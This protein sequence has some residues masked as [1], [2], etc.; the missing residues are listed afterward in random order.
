[1][2]P[3]RRLVLAVVLVLGATPPALAQG[4]AWAE[5]GRL[6]AFAA[7][8]R[9]GGAGWSGGAASSSFLPLGSFGGF[10][11][12]AP[13]PGQGLGVMSR[14]M[15]SES[16]GLSPEMAMPGAVSGLGPIR[17]SLSP[18]APITAGGAGPMGQG[19]PMGGAM[20]PA[21]RGPRPMGRPPVGAYPFRI[22]PSLIG[23][24][25]SGP[26]MAM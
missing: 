24:A 20:R 10:V 14:G 17:G 1:M 7:G 22:P 6:D 11:P 19:G 23:P 4:T 25:S 3:S 15:S 12:Y 2:S 5:G 13:G 21:A 26:A 9:L 16:R 18:L 8:A